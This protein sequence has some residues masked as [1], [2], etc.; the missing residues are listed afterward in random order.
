MQR[1]AA[2]LTKFIGGQSFSKAH[3]G[4]AKVTAPITIVPAAQQRRAL[5]LIMDVLTATEFHPDPS[6]YT[7]LVQPVGDCEVVGIGENCY[8]LHSPPVHADVMMRTSQVLLYLFDGARM[9]RLRNNAWSLSSRGQDALTVSELV[10]TVMNRIWVPPTS[11]NWTAPAD[12]FARDLQMLSLDL[13]NYMF[14]PIFQG[15]PMYELQAAAYQALAL[16]DNILASAP[17]DD[18]YIQLALARRRT[19]G[20]RP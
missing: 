19:L 17:H 3:V 8:G 20:P 13:V 7:S 9:E 18:P 2:Y 12:Q 6:L 1:A 16:L 11:G 10:M 14:K 5:A 15:A 4:D